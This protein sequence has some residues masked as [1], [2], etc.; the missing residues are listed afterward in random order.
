DPASVRF[1]RRVV[2]PV[3]D[4]PLPVLH[5]L[6]VGV[7]QYQNHTDLKLKFPADDAEAF[8]Q[9]WDGQKGRH[10]REIS[11]QALIDEDASE[12][13]VLMALRAMEQQMSAEDTAVILWSGHGV[14]DRYGKLRLL[15][16]EVDGSEE[17]QLQRTAIAFDDIA[18]PLGVLAERG[19]TLVF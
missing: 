1:R 19:P 9:A 7:G 10:Y 6:A 14:R 12:R 18:G 13:G 8:W 11:A 4:R 15:P 16:H 17:I 5:L 2:A 3:P